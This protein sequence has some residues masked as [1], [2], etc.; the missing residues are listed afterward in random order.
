[1]SIYI[2][3]DKREALVPLIDALVEEYRPLLEDLLTKT[4]VNRERTLKQLLR[5][6]HR[7]MFSTRKGRYG[8]DESHEKWVPAFRLEDLSEAE[9][10]LHTELRQRTEEG[11]WMGGQSSFCA[12]R[13][14][15][16]LLEPNKSP[17]R[18]K[19]HQILEEMLSG[20]G[21]D[22]GFYSGILTQVKNELVVRYLQPYREEKRAEFGDL[23]D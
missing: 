14:L 6:V 21:I 13:F 23:L 16:N 7:F 17:E 20:F 4:Q 8:P 2:P 15:V 9:V 10:A 11:Q 5:P 1:M 22:P 3:Q 12:F 19:R 18:Y